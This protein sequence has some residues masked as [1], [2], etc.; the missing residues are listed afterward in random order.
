MRIS[1]IAALLA[2]QLAGWVT[3]V[4]LSFPLKVVISG[5]FRSAILVTAA[6]DGLIL[7]L[8]AGMR[9]I[10]RRTCRDW[11]RLFRI[12][13]VSFAA[14]TLAGL[15]LTAVSFALYKVFG[16]RGRSGYNCK[17]RLPNLLHPRGSL[18][19]LESFVFLESNQ[20]G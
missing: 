14:S 4:L 7:L 16:F 17:D 2:I 13:L 3:Y 20:S 5:S 18:F 19:Q 12:F 1:S 6:R 8:T 10:Y 15:I 9:E 11:I